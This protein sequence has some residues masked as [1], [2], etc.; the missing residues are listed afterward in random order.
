MIDPSAIEHEIDGK[1]R[2]KEGIFFTGKAVV[3]EI[4]SRFDLK[5]VDS[6]IDTAA[7]SCN[8][9]LSLAAAY[10]KK[11]F[12]GVERNEQIYRAVLPAT[13]A[14][15]NLHYLRG[16]ILLDELPIPPCDLYLGNPPFINYTDLPPEYREKIRPL[17]IHYMPVQKGFSLLLGESRGDVA[18]LVFYHSISRYLKEKGRFGVV[19]PNSLIKGNRATESFRKFPGISV[20]RLVDI[21]GEEAFANT[22]RPCFYILGQKGGQTTYP[23]LYE[24]KGETVQLRKKGGLLLEADLALDEGSDYPIRQG[25]NTLGANGVYFFNEKPDLEEALLHPLLRSGDVGEN[26]AEP[27][28][29]VLLP[30]DGEGCL[31]EEK[32]LKK[33]YPKSWEYLLS[34][35]DKLEGRKSRFA[36]KSWYALFGI[37]PY[38]F[39]PWKV[40]WRA[41]GAKRLEAAVTDE[42]IPNQAMHGYIACRSREEADYLCALLNTKKMRRMAEILSESRSRS[43]A[44]P[45]TMKLLP[46]KQYKNTTGE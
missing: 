1:T 24:K 36:K 25:I 13:E 41:M 38:T 32:T 35:K 7:G 14:F 17:W 34:R 26:R 43:F 21:P 8:F 44:Q 12:Y 22:N 5:G 15:P 30:Y 20:E 39:A 37:G 28:R 6:V 19:L 45:G 10:P 29:W 11:Q 18:A 40:V 46:L 16:D 42:A 31:L 27:S 23:L 2:L 3:D 9:L 33:D 4:V